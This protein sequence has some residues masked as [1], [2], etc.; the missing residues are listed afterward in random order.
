MFK[1]STKVEGDAAEA[2]A[3]AHLKRHG[4]ALVQR[5]Y[6]IAR[7]PAARGGEIDLAL[8][9]ILK[10]GPQNRTIQRV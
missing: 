2:L 10:E 3:L 1:T 7:G 5:N 8:A 4:L 9:A 6:R